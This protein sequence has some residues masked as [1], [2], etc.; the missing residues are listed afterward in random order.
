M[1]INQL[2][3]SSVFVKVESIANVHDRNYESVDHNK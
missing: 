1:I 3:Q 2:I